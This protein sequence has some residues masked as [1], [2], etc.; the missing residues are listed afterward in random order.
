MHTVQRRPTLGLL[1]VLLGCIAGF[2]VL[3]TLFALIEDRPID[4]S[5]VACTAAIMSSSIVLI[6]ESRE[7]ARRVCRSGCGTET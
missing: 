6:A 7:P 5:I 4:L 3:W 1:A 2:G